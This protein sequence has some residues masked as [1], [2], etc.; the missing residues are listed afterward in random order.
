[1]N[2]LPWRRAASQ[3]SS[4]LLYFLLVLSLSSLTLL[5]HT[6]RLPAFLIVPFGLPG[7]VIVGGN[8]NYISS[9]NT[10]LVSMYTQTT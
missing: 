4:C 5:R 9:S 3:F 2:A 6:Q 10:E 7:D 1:L 8:K